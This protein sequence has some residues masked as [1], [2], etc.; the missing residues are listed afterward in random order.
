[1][2]KPLS[3]LAKLLLIGAGGLAVLAGPIL[4]L[5][6]TRTGSY[7]AWNIANPMTPIFMGANYLGG[8]GAVGAV[9]SNRWSVA[10]ALMPGIFAFAITQ[11]FATLF[12]IPIFNWH[13]PVAWAWLFV[14]LGSPG[15]TLLVYVWMERG[16]R[17]P[18]FDTRTIP[19][20]F[21]P[22]MLVFSIISATVGLALWAW[23]FN[24]STLLT[25][26]AVPWWAWSLTPLTAH[27][28]G[29]W[30]LSAATLYAPLSRPHPPQAVRIALIGVI[31]ATGLELVGAIWY[32]SAF[33]GRAV[34]TRFYILNAAA[35]FTFTLIARL[36]TKVPGVAPMS[37]AA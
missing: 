19:G 3:I 21:R 20:S 13:H 36:R 23:P 16:C 17:A 22:V 32:R 9:L 33:N 5:L 7:F 29:G 35:V 2:E 10:R 12:S 15:A 28:V 26:S 11:L 8:I 25:G 30:Y 31:A 6:P 34:S 1:M 27:V 14:Y 24:L 4:F 18:A 37:E